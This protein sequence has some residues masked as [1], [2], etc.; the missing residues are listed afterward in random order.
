MNYWIISFKY[1]C[2]TSD[3]GITEKIDQL[4][5]L[6]ETCGQV[7]AWQAFDIKM[8]SNIRCVAHFTIL[9]K[10]N[11][12]QARDAFIKPFNDIMLNWCEP[13]YAKAFSISKGK[14]TTRGFYEKNE[15]SLVAIKPYLFMLSKDAICQKT[16]TLVQGCIAS[17]ILDDKPNMEPVLYMKTKKGFLDWSMKEIT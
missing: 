3:H 9:S 15:S 7:L 8:P 4:N 16:T 6:M 12:R 13:C 10:F 5:H 1:D 14:F 2:L 11:R 17:D